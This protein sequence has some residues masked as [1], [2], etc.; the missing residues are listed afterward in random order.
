M[1]VASAVHPI[2]VTT[3]DGVAFWM[4]VSGGS[5]AL[6]EC[7]TTNCSSPA[8]VNN[9]TFSIT[10][11]NL[12]APSPI[13]LTDGAWLAWI[14]A[15]PVAT[16]NSTEPQ[17]A[18]CPIGNCTEATK[19]YAVSP[20]EATELAASSADGGAQ[21]L[22]YRDGQGG[23][24]SCSFDGCSAGNRTHI[25]TTDVNEYAIAADETHIY[26]NDLPFNAPES[27]LSCPRTGCTGPQSVLFA[28]SAEFLTLN[29]TYVVAL[30]LAGD[31]LA[32]KKS[33]CASVATH[34]ASGQL[35]VTSAVADD[36]AVY[37]TLGGTPGYADGKVMKCSISSNA[38]TPQ[39]LVTGLA[40]PTSLTLSDGVLYWAN[41]GVPVGA[42]DSGVPDGA[43]PDRSRSSRSERLRSPM[44]P[45]SR[46]AALGAALG[47]GAAL[48][49][50]VADAQQTQPEGHAVT[51]DVRAESAVITRSSAG[52][53]FLERLGIGFAL[54]GKTAFIGGA[55]VGTIVGP[56]TPSFVLISP[57]VGVRLLIE[58]RYAL[59]VTASYQQFIALDD[60]L[61]PTTGGFVSRESYGYGAT[62]GAAFSLRLSE[63]FWASLFVDLGAASFDRDTIYVSPPS[64]APGYQGELFAFGGLALDLRLPL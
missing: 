26:F 31:I 21:Q 20:A 44:T 48:S 60:S 12:D 62:V 5:I 64:I 37:Y 57:Y 7:P 30:S 55:Y 35:K 41:G 6:N 2:A 47:L 36:T 45:R 56:D 61:E 16:D 10:P 1:T 32:C 24:Y 51:I 58:P 13:L 43:R 4:D 54:G 28:G 52:A 18:A 40:S 23:L 3:A 42:A 11:T 39:A 46:G 53:G 22:F 50:G 59:D 19:T 8:S 9:G 38:C 14:A 33:G 63:V 49:P 15:D 34:L 27:V 29:T 17:V 25:G